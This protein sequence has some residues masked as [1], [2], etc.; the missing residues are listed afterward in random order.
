MSESDFRRSQS[1]SLPVADR[2]WSR[3]PRWVKQVNDRLTKFAQLE[4]GWDG[5]GGRP[6]RADVIAF[7]WSLLGSIMSARTP[8]PQIVP[9][10]SG[11]L[12]LEWHLRQIDIK[13]SVFE[14]KRVD[15]LIDLLDA[16]I[17]T[18]EREREQ[19]FELTSDFCPLAQ[20][21]DVL[22]SENQRAI[23]R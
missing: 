9:L 22:A 10:S 11:G 16:R 4:L 15:V 6:V 2:L 18:D 12:Q 7:V 1:G 20:F 5:H 17:L 13:I 3:E 14:P 8:A 19:D 23:N 21:I